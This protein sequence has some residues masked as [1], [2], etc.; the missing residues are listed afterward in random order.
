MKKQL[1][2]FFRKKLGLRKFLTHRGGIFFSGCTPPRGEG[3][4]KTVIP[5]IF[6]APPPP[7]LV[8]NVFSTVHQEYT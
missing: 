3:Y 5:R 2:V 7:L 1:V 6:F 4:K 8:T